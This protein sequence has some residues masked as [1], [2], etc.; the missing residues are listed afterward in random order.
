MDRK[1]LDYLHSTAL[2]YGQWR[3][4]GCDRAGI[5]CAWPDIPHRSLADGAGDHR[6]ATK[7]QKSLYPITQPHSSRSKPSARPLTGKINDQFRDIHEIAIRLPEPIKYIIV[8]MYYR[9]MSFRDVSLVTGV[10]S[11]KVG[12]LKYRFLE[13]IDSV[14]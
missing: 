4:G 12:K 1:R 8:F 10:E 7:R 9:G 13:S 11:K 3:T 2:D 5:Q 6:R 14:I